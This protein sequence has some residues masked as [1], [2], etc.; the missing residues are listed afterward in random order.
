MSVP[1]GFERLVRLLIDMDKIVGIKTFTLETEAADYTCLDTEY[2][3]VS[4]AMAIAPA[5]LFDTNGRLN[6]E[7]KLELQRCG[8]PTIFIDGY[9]YGWKVVGI[10]V[11]YKG[12]VVVRNQFLLDKI[13]RG[14]LP[15]E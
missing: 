14:E 5:V 9:K 7:A 15:N 8:F 13:E 2:D 6:F 4:T 10:E 12:L 11:P 3:L 1:K